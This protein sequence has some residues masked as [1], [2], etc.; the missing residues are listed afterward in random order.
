MPAPES[1]VLR[2]LLARTRRKNVKRLRG[3]HREFIA[4]WSPSAVESQQ[5]VHFRDA[6]VYTDGC[7]SG[8]RERKDNL[9]GTIAEPRKGALWRAILRRL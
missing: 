6:L 1:G 3:I 8:A 5:T 2:K 7:F 4:A 9:V